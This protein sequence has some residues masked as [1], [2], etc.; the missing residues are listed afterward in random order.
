M[1]LKDLE[2]YNKVTI[3]C[4]DI[5]DADALASGFAM[6]KYFASKG[7]NVS[8]IYSGDLEIQKSDLD[9]MVHELGIPVVHRNPDNKAHISGLLLMVDCQYGCGNVTKFTADTVAVIDHHQ[10]Q[11]E[12]HDLCEIRPELGSCSTLC[13]HLIKEAGYAVDDDIVLSTALFYGLNKDTGGFTD[14]HSKLDK[15]MFC[16]LEY[17]KGIY[18]K[19]LNANISVKELRTMGVALIR[20]LFNQIHKYAIIPY[21]GACDPNVLGIISDV[22]L[23]VNGVNACIVYNVLPN[24]YKLSVRSC[25]PMVKANEL[26]SFITRGIGS[27]GGHQTKAGGFVSLS[28]YEEAFDCISFDTYITDIMHEFYDTFVVGEHDSCECQHD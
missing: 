27:G 12:V 28:K 21:D 11:M 25:D 19:I 22:L 16:E 6:Y 5:P 20:S 26:T 17:D 8:F 7:A 15:T 9:L 14:M 4:H 10:I 18:D 1:I 23:S 24:G 2:G 13:Y 3:Q